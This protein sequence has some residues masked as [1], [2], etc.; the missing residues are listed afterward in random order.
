[1]EIHNDWSLT[2]DNSVLKVRS[3]LDIK[4]RRADLGGVQRSGWA[5]RSWQTTMTVLW[6]LLGS[7]GEGSPPTLRGRPGDDRGQ[8]PP[9]EKPLSHL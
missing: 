6:G 3:V 1:M 8:E 7:R 5:G 9:Q 4:G 2:V